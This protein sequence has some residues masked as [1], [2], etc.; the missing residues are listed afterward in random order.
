MRLSLIVPCYNE[1][2]NVAPFQD[3]VI[4]AFADC[5]YDYEIIF[6]DDGS[7][8]ATYHNLKKL[9]DAQT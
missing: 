6:V 8:D 2:E 3:A 5:G 1:A 9:F 7:K 4:G